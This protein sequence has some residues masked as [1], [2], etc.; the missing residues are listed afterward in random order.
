VRMFNLMRRAA[1]DYDHVLICFSANPDTPPPE[2]L[3]ICA[4]VVLVRLTGS[5][6]RPSTHRPDVVEEFDSPA[7]H[8]ALH[9]TVRKWRPKLAQLEFTQMAQYAADCAPVPAVLAEHDITFDLYEQLLS[10]NEDW[11]L[12][13][14]LDRWRKFETRAWQTVNRVV[15]MS[16]KDRQLVPGNR[17]VT[18]ANGVDLKRFQPAGGEPEPRRLLFI[19]SFAHLPNVLALEF[20]VKRVWPLLDAMA[21]A[22]HVIA[23]MRHEYFLDFYKDRANVDL[24]RPRIEVE[25]FVADVRPAYL[26]AAIVIAPLLASAGTNIKILEAMAMG[27]AIVSTTAGINGLDLDPGAVIVTDS[28]EQ[29]ASAILELFKNASHRRELES[30]ARQSV[31]L[32]FDWDSIARQQKQL[33]QSLAG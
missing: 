23:G 6:S 10:L 33:Y 26:R 12:R 19:G 30:R 18:L 2:L 11:E 14:Q 1:T 27:K 9:Q 3:A 21:P 32:R 28:A 29:M 4:E 15:T 24:R 31:E 13:R 20:F 17:A 7:F 22:L 8:A 5:H 25:G 16:E